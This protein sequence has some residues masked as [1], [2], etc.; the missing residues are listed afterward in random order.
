MKWWDWM[1]L[2]SYFECYFKPVLSFSSFTVIKML[3]SSSSL[4]AIRLVSSAYLR[5][6]TF[7]LAIL[8]PVCDSTSLVFCI[9]CSAYKLNKQGDNIYPCHT[10][11]PIVNQSV[12]PWLVPTVASWPTYR[13]LRRQ[14]KWSGIP[15]S[16]PVCCDPHSQRLSHNQWNRSRCFSGYLLSLFFL[17]TVTKLMS[18]NRLYA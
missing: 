15:I 9:I 5:L 12:V 6:L 1:P 8:I 16:F 7:L 17:F 2:S 4:C 18:T 3:F 11:F 13:F 10:P 14:V